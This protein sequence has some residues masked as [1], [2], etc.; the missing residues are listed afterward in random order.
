MRLVEADRGRE[1]R[2]WHLAEGFE[3][4]RRRLQRKKA[5]RGGGSY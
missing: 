4:R 2:A 1:V 5:R 3:R